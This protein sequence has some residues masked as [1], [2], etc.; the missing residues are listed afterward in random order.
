MSEVIKYVSTTGLVELLLL[1]NLERPQEDGLQ[2]ELA[3]GKEL[4]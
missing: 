4:V 2:K 1:M 3:A